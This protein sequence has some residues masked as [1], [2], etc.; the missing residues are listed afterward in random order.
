MLRFPVYRL[1]ESSALF[2][3]ISQRQLCQISS[4]TPDWVQQIKKYFKQSNR[5]HR[6]R[7][8]L[9]LAGGSAVAACGYWLFCDKIYERLGIR[10]A[11][12][13]KQ[14]LQ[15]E[16]VR[17]TTQEAIGQILGEE[18]TL[19]HSHEHIEKVVMA[20]MKSDEF[21]KSV[22]KWLVELSESPE[23]TDRLNQMTK[24][25]LKDPATQEALK[26]LLISAVDSDEVKGQVASTLQASAI[27]AVTRPITSLFSTWM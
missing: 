17:Q 26:G 18:Q 24:N 19:K 4:R 23:V 11:Q 1:V 6:K 14:V 16:S 15:D 10:G 13:S 27:I 2:P 21:N 5:E 12:V 25:H 3:S 8:F 9:W 22:K 20:L 7:T